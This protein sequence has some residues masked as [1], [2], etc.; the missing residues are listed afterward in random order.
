VTPTALLTDADR[1][2]F[3]ADDRALLTAAGVELR[4]LEGHDPDDVVRA[5]RGVDA[6]FVY[7]ARFPR[8]TIAQLDGV[9]VLARCG[10]GYDNIDVAAARA[11]GIEVVYVPD[12]GVD[13]VADHALAVLLA[14]ARR[15]AQSDRA[16]RAGGWPPYSDL[17]PMRRL[18]SCTLGVV[19][20]GRIGR[21]LAAKGAALGLRVLVH[22]P[23]VPDTSI[24]LRRLLRESDFVSLHV[25]LNDATRHMIGR[26]ELAHMR[27]TA[28]LVNTARGGLV[29]TTALA[30]AL[31]AGELGGAAL[32]VF[33]ETPLPVD[34]PLRSL[35]NVV[36]TPH[37]AAYTEEALAE[38]RK[39]PLADA[40]RVLRGETPRDAA[41]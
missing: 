29:D 27:P 9:R 37:S 31:R 18:R 15:V 34:H 40:L 23:Y 11:Q 7:H 22:D 28:I 24:D 13:D 41:P 10:A 19:G 30:D 1:F 35:D 5:A 26:S 39:R 16:I 3:D 25:P 33:E 14:S 32:D 2:P 17:A 20:Y 6:V 8:E 12:Y 4:E 36:L 21:N 38:V